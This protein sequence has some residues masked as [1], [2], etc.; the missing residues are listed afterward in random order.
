[1]EIDQLIF[2]GIY[3]FYKK[4][5][6]KVDEEVVQRTVFLEPL[7]PRLTILLRALTGMQNEIVTSEREGG[8]SGL[9]IYLPKSI[10]FNPTI[11]DN[12][13]YYLFRVLYLSV[14][15][16]LD[17]NWIDNE[18]HKTTESQQKATI[19]SEQVLSQLFIEYPNTKQI[20]ETQ[21]NNLIEFFSKQKKE[22]DF[23][24]LFGRW[25]KKHPYLFN[26]NSNSLESDTN[27]FEK[28]AIT[29]EL[30]ANAS[31]EVETVAINQKQMED[32]V[33][34]NNFEKVDTLSEF[35]GT[36]KEMD[37]DDTLSD[38]EEAIRELNLKHT[39][40]TDEKNHSV[41]K[42]E[43]VNS[44]A[45]IIVENKLDAGYFLHYDEWD[46]KNRVYKPN[47]CKVYPKK[48]G[49]K[50]S[51][52]ALKTLKEN[53]KT[54]KALLNLFTKIHN[55]YE[56]VERVTS[57]EEI[58]LDAV[59]DALTDLYSK[60]TPSDKIYTTK[61]K[62]KKDLS[63]LILMDTSLSSEGY[64]NNEKVLDVEKT[65]VL[66]FGEVLNEFGISFQIDTFSS[67]TRNNC[68]YKSIKT[69]NENWVTARNRIGAIEAEDYTR[70]G[71]ALR[72]AGKLLEK[73]KTSRKW[74]I[75]LSDGKPND[76]DTYEGIYGI[77]DVK[78][79]LQELNNKHIHS[80]SLAIEAQAK[81]YLPQMFG[82]N[83]YNIL[84][85]PSDLPFAFGKFY[86]KILNN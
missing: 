30:D 40:R 68:S 5:T 72:H 49:E 83:N 39:V 63:V 57:G 13:N 55:E 32:N 70:I 69:F 36:F 79:A 53:E 20:Y 38:D 54:K 7:K 19:F 33:A 62:K 31:D 42:A 56:K 73:E 59:I 85:K 25:M 46:Y 21:K 10:S 52:Y 80:F 47:F 82:H 14:Q 17:L 74:I 43:F 35:N 27:E 22:P 76:Y 34:T 16:K 45:N 71:T 60:K 51:N 11:E 37:G 67:R 41:Y 50:F 26:A 8:W 77:E 3:D 86:K 78:K 1:M 58:D 44:K 2:K 81:Y 28:P 12:V 64:T 66:L 15:Q 9:T 48:V 23:T 65:S 84:P 29:T 6:V 18:N 75:L 24:W 4:L 61:R